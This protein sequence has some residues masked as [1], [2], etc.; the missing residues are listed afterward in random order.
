[1]RSIIGRVL[2]RPA[3]RV[4]LLQTAGAGAF[5]IGAAQ[6]YGPAGWIVGGVLLCV[7]AFLIEPTQ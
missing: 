7:G 1:M 3:G 5:T 6:I 2:H 4:A